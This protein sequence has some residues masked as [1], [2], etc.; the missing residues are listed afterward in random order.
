M[1]KTVSKYKY[2]NIHAIIIILFTLNVSRFS[3]LKLFY[4]RILQINEIS[5][6]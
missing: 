2:L 5:D 4:F 6:E 3:S 1:I